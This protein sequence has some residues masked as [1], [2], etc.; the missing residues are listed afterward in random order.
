[1][2]EQNIAFWE[3]LK[4]FFVAQQKQLERSSQLAQNA[5]MNWTEDYAQYAHDQYQLAIDNCDAAIRNLQKIK[6]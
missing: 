4:R 2:L 3:N 5:G 6:R 1:M